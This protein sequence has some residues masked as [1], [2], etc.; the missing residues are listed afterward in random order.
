MA[1]RYL[2]KTHTDF[3]DWRPADAKVGHLGAFKE[4]RGMIVLVDVKC[5]LRSSSVWM[6]TFFV[7]EIMDIRDD[8]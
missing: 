5:I 3:T 6:R 8:R 4:S 2:L 7:L 1:L